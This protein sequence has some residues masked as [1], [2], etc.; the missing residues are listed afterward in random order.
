MAINSLSDITSLINQQ[1]DAQELIN[2]YLSKIES[3]YCFTMWEDFFDLEKSVLQTY[4]WV[5]SDLT[6]E[7]KKLNEETL[8]TLLSN[9][10][11]FGFR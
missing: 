11:D 9:R 1:I 4:F 8:R 7:A 6:S 3:L 10:R 2:E 5:L